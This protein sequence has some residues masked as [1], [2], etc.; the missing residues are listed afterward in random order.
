M[1]FGDPRTLPELVGSAARQGAHALMVD[2]NYAIHYHP[3]HRVALNEAAIRHRL[4]VMH[5]SLT[6]AAD[7]ALMAHGDDLTARWRRAAYFVDRIL[8]GDRPGDI[9]IEHASRVE[10]H[11]NLNA[12]KAIGLRIPSTLLLQADRV[13]E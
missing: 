8:R 2:A 13:F 7:G 3:T 1:T 10:F 9:P 11:I 12:A 6:G 5:L 4:L